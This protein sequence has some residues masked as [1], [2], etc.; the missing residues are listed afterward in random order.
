MKQVTGLPMKD[1]DIL[2]VSFWE[3]ID[4]AVPG[5]HRR[6]D[7]IIAVKNCDPVLQTT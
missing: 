1:G 7:F 2:A 6:R 4:I 5:N 3:D